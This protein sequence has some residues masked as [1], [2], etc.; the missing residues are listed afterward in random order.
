MPLQVARN[1]L[2]GAIPRNESSGRK[3]P[4]SCTAFCGFQLPVNAFGFFAICETLLCKSKVEQCCT[5][6]LSAAGKI[7]FTYHCFKNSS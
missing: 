3:T 6:S 1:P 4:E 5:V 7:T 2:T